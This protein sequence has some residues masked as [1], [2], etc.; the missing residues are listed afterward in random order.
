MRDDSDEMPTG[1]DLIEFPEVCIRDFGA[2]G[3]V[4]TSLQ[5]HLVTMATASS[6]Y[7]NLQCL[8]NPADPAGCVCRFDVAVQTGGSGTYEVVDSHT[9]IHRMNV[10]FPSNAAA[11][12]F[13]QKVSYGSAGGRLQLTGAD[14]AYLFD[15]PGLRTM[16]LAT[17]TIKCTDGAQGPGED[18]ID[19]GLACPNA[20]M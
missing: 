16:E 20:C 3:D 6:V 1:Q 4:C 2:V 19:C 10:K 17:T 7:K 14:G 12:A 8:A 11:A 15:E 9:L 5:T 18:G 13:P